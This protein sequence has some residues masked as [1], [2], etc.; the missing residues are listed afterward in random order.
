MI[1]AAVPRSNVLK[2]PP[3]AA[4]PRQSL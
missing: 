1:F 4:K 2:R 3:R